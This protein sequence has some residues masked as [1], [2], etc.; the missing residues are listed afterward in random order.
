MGRKKKYN[1]DEE[2]KEGK[3]LYY[4][5]YRRKR[6]I[7][8]KS[9]YNLD[10]TKKTCSKCKE[11]K[12]LS[13]FCKNKKTKDGLNCK[14]KTC[15]NKASDKFRETN[16]DYSKIYNENNIEKEK[17]RKNKYYKDNVEK[18]LERCG[19]YRKDNLEYYSNYS[20]EY[21]KKNPHIKASRNIVYNVLRR[22]GKKKEGHTIDLLGYSAL[23]LKEYIEK[24]FTDGMKWNNYGE[25]HI[26]HIK[27][28]SE[29]DKEIS[30]NIIN[31]LSNLR[32]LWATS[33]IIN[34][35]FYEGNLN[36]G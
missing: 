2:R 32:P 20:K 28:V 14:C 25:W 18:I 15:C 30:M 21:L 29:F 24:L 9:T 11:E 17:K 8:Q 31:A 19:N 22:L 35:I 5:E 34:G 36:R 23:D 13:N 4:V 12:I 7:K 3:R 33:R 1:T 6:G 26:D 10:R 27:R 16:P